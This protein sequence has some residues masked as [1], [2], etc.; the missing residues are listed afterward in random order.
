M[1]YPKVQCC[2][3]KKVFEVKQIPG[4][5]EPPPYSC[6]KLECDKERMRKINRIVA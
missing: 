4:P 6:G 5:L 2:R 3:C 1:K